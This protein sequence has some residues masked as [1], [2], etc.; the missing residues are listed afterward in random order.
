MSAPLSTR[1]VPGVRAAASHDTH[2]SPGYDVFLAIGQLRSRPKRAS[3]LKANIV[4]DLELP[5]D[6][7]DGHCIVWHLRYLA[8]IFP[9][10]NMSFYQSVHL[11][12]IASIMHTAA[13]LSR[14]GSHLNVTNQCWLI[15]SQ[16]QI[17]R[18]R[19]L[20]RSLMR[21]LLH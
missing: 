17:Q 15:T 12:V 2:E 9:D 8:A 18:M 10:S 11:A 7:V 4:G 5:T 16:Q 6:H 21:Q 20:M 14:P 19:Y 13:D 3:I 1:S